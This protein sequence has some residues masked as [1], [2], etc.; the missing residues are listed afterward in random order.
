ME[1]DR[2]KQELIINNILT[3]T[4]DRMFDI[5]KEVDPEDIQTILQAAMAAPTGVNRQ[6]W[7]YVVV[8]NRQ[9]LDQLAADLPYCHFANQVNAAIVVCGDKDRFLE[10]EDAQ[11]WIQDVSA[12][13]EN[14]LLAAHALGLGSVWTCV[15]PHTDRMATVAGILSLPDNMIPFNVIPIGYT[16]KSHTPIN[17]W[18][19]AN[20]LYRT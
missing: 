13:S 6:P 7:N 8:T 20:I 1:T 18:N 16:L 12:S 19:P 15:Y 2:E 5:S 17:K 11:L 14:I 3:R 4:S 10:G 9:L